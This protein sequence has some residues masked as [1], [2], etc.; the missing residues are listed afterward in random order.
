MLALQST[1]CQRRSTRVWLWSLLERIMG[2]VD[3]QVWAWSDGRAWM[4][5]DLTRG[6]TG[7]GLF[8][9]PGDP[10]QETATESGSVYRAGDGS[11]VFV[12]ADG[13]DAVISGSVASEQL[14][15]AAA[16]LP[17]PHLQVP[18]TWPEA[19]VSEA[20][21]RAAYFPVDVAGLNDP[22]IHAI[23]D[24]IV[25]D[26]FGG[27]QRWVRIT[28][29][30][31]DRISPPLDPDARAIQ[32]RGLTGRYSPTFGVL[33]WSEQGLLFTVEAQGLTLVEVIA[34]AESLA[35]DRS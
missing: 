28:Q 2:L 31:G 29:Q 34:V 11:R 33:E 32:L 21:A 8:G 6:W 35:A 19:P 18:A 15:A 27:G 5:L 1:R 7:P 22:I 30:A 10:V 17:G 13:F 24:A 12:H 23:N 16:M 14:V 3:T 20:L 25:I 4:R 9:N 26:L